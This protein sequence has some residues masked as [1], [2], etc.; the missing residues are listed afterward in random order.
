MPWFHLLWIGFLWLATALL[1]FEW[2]ASVT[3]Y[4]GVA[5]NFIGMFALIPPVYVLDQVLGYATFGAVL[6]AIA[7]TGRNRA[8]VRRL[9]ALLAFE[10][11]AL[12][13]SSVLWKSI[14]GLAWVFALQIIGMP[15]VMFAVIAMA[16]RLRTAKA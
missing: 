2:R 15:L 9:P 5:V 14:P 1:Y 7:C 11:L 8:G 3:L 16:Q 13:T 10:Q 12:C 4:V 6:G